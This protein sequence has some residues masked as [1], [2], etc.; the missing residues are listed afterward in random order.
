MQTFSDTT[1]TFSIKTT[2]GKSV[3]G[4]QSPYVIDSGFSPALNKENNVF[5]TPRMICS[6][7]NENIALAGSKS[8]TFSAL[9]KTS[10]DSVS[11]V[12]DTSRAS[13]IAISNKLNNPTESNTNVAAIDNVT[14]FTG[15]TGAFTFVSGGTL[16]STNS[17]V[18]TAMAG[19]GIGK[20]VTISSATTTGNNGTFLVTGFSDDGTTATLTLNT[21]FTG[22]SAVTGTTVTSRILFASEIAPIGSSTISKYVTTPV[23]FANSSTYLRIMLAANIPAE[24][25]VSVYYKTCTGDSSK[26]SNAKYT[27]ATPD[28][29]VIKVDNGD[30]TF[31]DITYTLTG[32]TSFDTVVVKI[33]MNSSNTSAVPIIKDFRIIA[34]P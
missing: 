2:S 31:S 18:R 23:K 5:Y 15:A 26:L 22:E 13:L 7:T 16:T 20:Y 19:I 10:N 24:A 6:E 29:S 14:A 9:L 25:N 34:C 27:L 1:N 28:G 8:V 30:P 4:S 21:T 12:I 3:D 17:S 33:V 32:I 11:P